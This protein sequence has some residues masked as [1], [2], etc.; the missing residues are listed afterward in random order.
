[1]TQISPLFSNKLNQSV[2]SP[3][4]FGAINNAKVDLTTKSDSIDL[5]KNNFDKKK[6]LKYGTIGIAFLGLAAGVAAIIKKGKVPSEILSVQKSAND[7][8]KEAISIAEGVQ[9]TV[10]NE[11]KPLQE[12]A[13]KLAEEIKDRAEKIKSEVTELFNNGG[14]KGGIQ[15]AD[16]L[17]SEDE[18]SLMKEF[19]SDG[20]LLRK[21]R[22]N[23]NGLLLFVE[24]SSDVGCTR[25]KFSNGSI[26]NY[27]EGV[28]TL[29]DG[30]HKIAKSL[31]LYAD[32]TYS[33]KF[34]LEK[35]PDKTCLTNK[36]LLVDGN[37]IYEYSE[38][39]EKSPNKI[40]KAAKKF[41]FED[42]QLSEYLEDFEK[43]PDGS[44][45]TLKAL[46]FDNG[47][48][49]AYDKLGVRIPNKTDKYAQYMD[50]EDGKAVEYM[51][52]FEERADDTIK[53][54]K[55]LSFLDGEPVSYVEGFESM[56]DNDIKIAKSLTK[57]GSK[58]VEK[59]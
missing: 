2:K 24:E 28:E 29:A 36:S 12:S 42:G 6:I 40:N 18:T 10:D 46:V 57:E 15:A 32:G 55:N 11:I 22:F 35:M 49:V 14:K 48:I 50:F 25:Y 38:G 45:K 37:E 51:E 13:E 23:S 26:K 43:L 21:S 33:Y 9:K 31:T 59:N 41:I 1:M 5:S 19:N 3:I 34:G 39:L 54:A 30:T 58:W 4:K 52:D 17:K 56:P 7:M 16:I 47:E 44:E 20:K 53:Y 8:E 27:Q